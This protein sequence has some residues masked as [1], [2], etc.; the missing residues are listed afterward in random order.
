MDKR[1]LP[2]TQSYPKPDVLNEIS[3]KLK[4]LYVTYIKQYKHLKHLKK[5]MFIMLIDFMNPFKKKDSCNRALISSLFF[6][7]SSHQIN[8]FHF[9]Q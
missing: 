3:R 8:F 7:I 4:F 9:T 2:I 5:K 6:L 1:I